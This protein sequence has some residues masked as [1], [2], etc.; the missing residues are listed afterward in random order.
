MPMTG[1]DSQAALEI[2][3]ADNGISAIAFHYRLGYI[4]W[5]NVRDRC[6][7]RAN[8]DG[9]NITTLVMG[10]LSKPADLAVDWI[11]D[12]LYWSDSGFKRIEEVDLHTNERRIVVQL[13]SGSN[14]VGLAVYPTM[15][16]GVLYWTDSGNRNLQRI[17]NT[18]TSHAVIHQ[19][20]CV[21]PIALKP[22][23]ENGVLGRPVYIFHR[24]RLDQRDQP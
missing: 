8:M 3:A 21:Q 14:P 9:T 22:T 17:L 13:D 16:H 15:E 10:D 12:K 2:I 11:H 24:V 4:F 23:R 18:G 6:I 19:A 20:N 5:I 1:A 7:K